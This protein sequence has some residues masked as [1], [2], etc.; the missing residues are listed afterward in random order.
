M[1]P[2]I[3]QS[4]SVQH[5]AHLLQR[6]AVAVEFAFVMI[7]ILMMTAGIVEFGRVFWYYNA[8]DKATHDAARYI[9]A[10]PATDMTD[11]VKASAA[12]ATAKGLV[13][14]AVSDSDYGARINPAITTN[15]VS[16]ICDSGA[17]NGTK[18]DNVSVSIT[19]FSISI[20]A[21]IPFVIG[22]SGGK[23]AAV[24]LSPSTTMRYMN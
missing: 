10:L 2:L 21:W 1:N 16:V 9:S 17:C 3:Y 7:V 24:P 4:R 13:V 6:G 5:S 15:N 20:G 22:P 23:Y 18:P 12:V 11:S 19:G 8:L 14:S